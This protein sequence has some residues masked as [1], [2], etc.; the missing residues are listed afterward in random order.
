MS[1]LCKIFRSYISNRLERKKRIRKKI[2][3]ESIES[4]GDMRHNLR[5]R[6]ADGNTKYILD[7]VDRAY[8]DICYKTRKRIEKLP[9]KL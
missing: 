8:A 2:I 9:I 3:Q 5:C 1:I 6:I 4:L 7:Y